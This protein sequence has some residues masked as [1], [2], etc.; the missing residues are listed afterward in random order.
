MIAKYQSLYQCSNYP[1]HVDA[2]AAKA[3]TYGNHH[4]WLTHHPF[5]QVNLGLSP[6]P[7]SFRSSD[8]LD[9]TYISTIKHRPQTC[10]KKA[11]SAESRAVISSDQYQTFV[12][13]FHTTAGDQE[14]SELFVRVF[15]VRPV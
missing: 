13:T 5:K 3:T 8:E 2:N 15:L 14:Q 12:K 10:G 6:A 11:D 1:K 7:V 9:L 4:R